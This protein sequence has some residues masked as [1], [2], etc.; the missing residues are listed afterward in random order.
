MQGTTEKTEFPTIAGGMGS[1]PEV[2]D[3]RAF[4]A[5]AVVSAIL[6]ICFAKPLFDLL[7]LSMR[8]DI[9][10]HLLLIP[11]ISL[12]L[13]WQRRPQ[14]PPPA[15]GSP[16]L[17]LTLALFPLAL[18]GLPYL[19]G[20]FPPIELLS[21]RILA[22]CMFLPLAIAGTLGLNFLRAVLFPVCFLLFL[23][24]LPPSIINPLETASKIGS[25]ET[26]NWMMDLTQSTYFRQGFT[27]A[28]PGLTIEVAQECSGIRSSL[29]LFI[30]SVLASNLFLTTTWKRV[31][32]SIF[33]IPLGILRNAFRIF[34]LS[35]LSVHWD[36]SVID[37]PLHH[38]GGP[39]FFALS[40]I[41]FFLVLFWLRKTENFRAPAENPQGD[42]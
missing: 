39:L 13:V 24:P 11:A 16:A 3:R 36:R 6:L 8:D 7:R 5:F 33:V 37:S 34:T 40:L 41:P 18:L 1:D 32:F 28:L 35:T 26:Y 9:Y 27:F 10:S 29:V 17:A 31:F 15:N 20:P 30:V 23:V 42:L 12:Y 22:F 19:I 2:V 38:R 25:T 21:I 14:L 4:R